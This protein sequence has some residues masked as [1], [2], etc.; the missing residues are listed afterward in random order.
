MGW[1]RSS[2]ELLLYTRRSGGAILRSQGSMATT[3]I[4]NQLLNDVDVRVLG[5]LVEKE[6]TTPDNYPLSLNGVVTA[7]NQASNRYPVVSYDD[8]TVSA[9][10]DRLR[11]Q[12]LVR[13]I[14]RSD[15]RV[16][17]Y[18]HLM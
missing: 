16:T 2:L 8:T 3:E 6:I 14:Q 5:A 12:S 18:Q 17:K 13:G 7:C 11:R 4:M 15:S 9:A 10:I 1:R